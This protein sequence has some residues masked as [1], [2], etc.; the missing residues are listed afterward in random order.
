MS[1]A[2]ILKQNDTFPPL[3]AKLKEV[4]A[5]KE[6]AIDLSTAEKVK[7][8]LKLKG[9][10]GTVIEGECTILPGKEGEIEYEWATGDTKTIGIYEVE[11]KIQ[12]APGKIE[13][14]PNSSY[15]EI[16]IQAAL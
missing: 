11:F 4:K 12:W 10:G 13:S 7:I 14:A 8:V 9:A 5:A 6:Q 16:E 1:I 2:L 15:D 3:E